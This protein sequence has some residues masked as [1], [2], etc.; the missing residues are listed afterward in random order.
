MLV[1]KNGKK[2]RIKIKREGKRVK[3]EEKF[4]NVFDCSTNK[5][6]IAQFQN[7][8]LNLFA[9]ILVQKTVRNETKHIKGKR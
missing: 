5:E 9:E 8:F 6:Q 7:L 3:K 1:Q 2:K 4:V